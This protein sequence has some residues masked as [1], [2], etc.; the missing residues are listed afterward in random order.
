MSGGVVPDKW[1]SKLHLAHRLLED[2]GEPGTGF[3]DRPVNIVEVGYWL[4]LSDCVGVCI[5]ES[6]VYNAPQPG[7]PLPNK[8]KGYTIPPSYH[9]LYGDKAPTRDKSFDFPIIGLKDET[10]ESVSN[11][12]DL[13]ISTKLSARVYSIKSFMNQTYYLFKVDENGQLVGSGPD[14]FRAGGGITRKPF[15]SQFIDRPHII[16][17]GTPPFP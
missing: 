1:E 11:H 15:Q 17:R 6:A 5:Y 4:Q 14:I 3:V 2:S 7:I 16:R 8:Y 10:G 9:E 12:I 13:S